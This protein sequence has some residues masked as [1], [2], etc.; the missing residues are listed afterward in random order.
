MM[1]KGRTLTGSTN[2]AS[3]IEHLEKWYK[4]SDAKQKQNRTESELD[5]KLTG[6]IKM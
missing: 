6:H 1:C 4:T 2:T 3:E 5:Y